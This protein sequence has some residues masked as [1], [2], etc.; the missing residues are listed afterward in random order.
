[1]SGYCR[2]DLDQKLKMAYSEARKTKYWLKLLNDILGL[3]LGDCFIK[4][5]EE[6]LRS[7]TPVLNPDKASNL[8][9]LTTNS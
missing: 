2:K 9:F 4:D 3:T 7:L 8:K 6:I 1:M 5:C